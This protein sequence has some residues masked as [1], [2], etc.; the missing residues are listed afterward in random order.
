MGDLESLLLVIAAIYLTECAV[1]VR[2]SSVAAQTGWG[3][4]WRLRHPGVVWGNAHGAVVLANPLPPLGTVLLSHPFPVSL[5]PQAMLSFTAVCLDAGGR[6]PQAAHWLKY[7]EAQTIST[8]GKSV[9]VNGTDFVKASSPTAARRLAGLLRELKG[10]T[11]RERAP[12]I[13]RALAATLNAKAARK[14]WEEFHG[15]FG[16]PS[17]SSSRGN[18]API[19]SENASHAGDQSLLTSAATIFRIRSQ[20]QGPRLR[21][22]GNILFVY[23]FVISPALIWYFGFRLAGLWVVAGL[24][25]QTFTIGWRFWRA[26]GGLYPGGSEERFVPFLTMLLAPPSAIRAHDLLA[27]RLVENFHP[28]VVAE[29]F[30]PGAPLHRLARRVLLDLCF[31]LLPSAPSSE[32]AVVQP[33][34]WFRGVLSEECERAVERAGLKPSELTQPPARSEATHRSYCPRCDAQFVVEAGTCADCGGRALAAFL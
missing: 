28:L 9:L 2:R 14:R 32:A 7:S 23:L 31:P 5:S 27:R 29:V 20:A 30:C 12:A 16:N 4:Q 33:E 21:W 26:H 10:L 19:S 22:L 6:P 11:E 25:A 1:W 24:L 15:G 8:E 18:E 3:S 13:R 17:L 34:E